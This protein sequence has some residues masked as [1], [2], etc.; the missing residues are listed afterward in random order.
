VAEG[1]LIIIAIS[2][3]HPPTIVASARTSR[4]GI[5]E[6]ANPKSK[7]SAEYRREFYGTV[8]TLLAH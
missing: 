3:D 1:A 2:D 7:R 4:K 8:G 6:T 5:S